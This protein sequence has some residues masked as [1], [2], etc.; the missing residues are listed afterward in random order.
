MRETGTAGNDL[1]AG[2]GAVA[3][4]GWNGGERVGRRRWTLSIA[5]VICRRRQTGAGVGTGGDIDVQ[6]SVTLSTAG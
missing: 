2:R 1:V 3:S 5:S 6:M 4:R